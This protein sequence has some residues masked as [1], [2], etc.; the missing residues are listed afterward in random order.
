MRGRKEA[1]RSA[2]V[3]DVGVTGGAAEVEAPQ[4]P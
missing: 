4:Q 3:S 2:V 1:N